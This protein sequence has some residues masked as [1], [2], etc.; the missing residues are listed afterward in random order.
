MVDLGLG[1]AVGLLHTL[2]MSYRVTPTWE[3]Q[4]LIFY[5]EIQ[6]NLIPLNLI[7]QKALTNFYLSATLQ[8]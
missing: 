7:S 2:D 3:I 4:V 1:L 8:V 5:S 6:K